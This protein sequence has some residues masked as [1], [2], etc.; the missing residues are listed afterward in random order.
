M[1]DAVG[2]IMIFKN[3]HVLHKQ[4]KCPSLPLQEMPSLIRGRGTKI[5]DATQSSQK[6]K[7]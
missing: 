5:P 7:V 6:N 2:E 1:K 3:V 4:L